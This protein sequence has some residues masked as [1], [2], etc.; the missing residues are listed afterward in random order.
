[1]YGRRT[2]LI[3]IRGAMT[4][5]FYRD[6]ILVPIVKGYADHFGPDLTLVDDNAELEL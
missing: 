1:M 3:H 6:N 4:G 5:A 2:P